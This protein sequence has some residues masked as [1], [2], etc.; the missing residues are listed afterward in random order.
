VIRLA[1]RVRRE[2]AEIALA[3]LLELAPS[4]VEEIEHDDQTVEYAV[5]GAPGEL[6]DLPALQASVGGALV[7]VGTSEVADDWQERWKLFH[8]PVSVPAPADGGAPA[9]RL[10][11]P[12]EPSV[13]SEQ[14]QEI[15]IDPGQ[16]FGTGAH[17]TTKLCL[18][19]LL[20]LAA[21]G[22]QGSLVD[23]GTGSGVLAIAAAKLGF[24][25]VLA[26]DHDP[27]SV[28]AAQENAQVNGVQLEIARADIRRDS[29]PALRG[30][31]V[32]ANLLRPLLLEL[33]ER[34]EQAPEHLV[35]SGLL[36]EETD[37]VVQALVLQHGFSERSRMSEGE[38]AASWLSMQPGRRLPAAA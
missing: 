32:L 11:P 27:E 7:Q 17:A 20:Q 14:A 33:C 37:E 24:A 2:Q 10:R 31:T 28:R 4:G 8:R 1:L 21:E 29:L 22:V 16:A 36:R 13:G 12:W 26:L 5:Y 3:N 18:S 35:V 30:A 9:L 34:I 15:V 38:W 19:L 6:P 25:P 23:I